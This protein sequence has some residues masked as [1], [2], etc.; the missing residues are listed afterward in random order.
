MKGLKPSF[1]VES[2]GQTLSIQPG[3]SGGMNVFVINFTDGSKP[4]VITY[5]HSSINGALWKSIPEGREIE[6]REL[7]ALITAYY[8]HET[9]VVRSF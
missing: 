1:T 8:E 7:G 2:E 5:A 3:K 9:A 6:A 4:L